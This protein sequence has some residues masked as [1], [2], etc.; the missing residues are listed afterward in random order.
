MRKF[1]PLIFII[2]IGLLVRTFRIEHAPSRLT[3]DEMSIGYNAYSIAQTGLDEWGRKLPLSFEAFGDYKLPGYIYSVVPFISLIGLNTISLKLPSII[4]GIFIIIFS[5]F[6]TLKITNNQQTSL[7]TAA[8]IALSPWPIHISR[9]ALE[10]NLALAFYSG[11]LFF[12]LSIFDKDLKNETKTKKEIINKKSLT[13]K[14]LLSGLLF[15]LSSYTYVAFRLITVLT[16]FSL[17]IINIKKKKQ[18]KKSFLIWLSFLVI[19]IPLVPQ[20]LG[21][22]GSARFSQ[23][24][25]F[26]DQGI[27]AKVTEQRNF[28]F[29]QQQSGLPKLCKV[30][31]NKYFYIGEKISKNYLS[32]IL[33]T[34]IFLDGDKLEY[35]NNPDFGQF[36]IILIPF[37]LIGLYQLV[38]N[39]K[40]KYGDKT[41]IIY[42][43]LA[44]LF[45]PLSSALV[46][47]P[48]IVR[49]S[50]LLLFIA[51]F[52]AIG[53]TY[54]S[55]LIKNKNL[56]KISLAVISL[57]FLFNFSQ[58]FISYNYIYAAQYENYIY[59]LDQRTVSHLNEVENNFDKIYISNHFPDA[60]ILLAFYNKI[61][62]AYYQANIIRPI[63]DGFGFAHPSNLGKYHFGDQ[64]LIE[65]LCLTDNSLYLSFNDELPAG[66][67]IEEN[68]ANNY[69]YEIKGFSGVH[70]QVKFFDLK[71]IKEYLIVNNL[72][73]NTCKNYTK[74]LII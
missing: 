7:F 45:T 44:F 70:T 64:K 51:I 22:S 26:S 73:E 46:G 13:I 32:F 39:N 66:W 11:G 43:L 19:L 52:S 21:R 54:I 36:S 1:L 58:Y 53:L 12:S 40:E 56:Q 34:F 62:P 23:V 2:L 67:K 42:L 35:L 4:A 3:H 18:L 69:V 41:K 14:L 48:Q 9:M 33:P 20:L 57:I 50:G 29:L 38:Q 8:L 72:L 60:H 65:Q 74:L 5:Y 24:S 63:A 49:G 16:L 28:C 61:D 47:D 17:S 31:Y 71:R 15:A 25:I 30:L 37:Y 68:E 55:S 59:Q 27:E 10:S 6:I